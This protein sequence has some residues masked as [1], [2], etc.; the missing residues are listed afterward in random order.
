MKRISQTLLLVA[1]LFLAA[2]IATD[3]H[4]ADDA[5]IQAT[6]ILGTNDGGGVDSQLKRYEKNLKRVLR[7]DTFRQKGSG[8][9]SVSLPGKAS[10][11]VGQGQSVSIEA[12]DAGGGK[13]RIAARWAQISTTV[14]TPRGQ[15]TVL[16]GPASG[17]GKL[18]LL[19]VA[20]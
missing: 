18:I 17:S 12:S 10:I 20:N 5:R 19:L 15:P 6:L 7:F 3:S 1:T 4:A 8:S 11:N 14:V 16:V 2:G 9:A 13:L